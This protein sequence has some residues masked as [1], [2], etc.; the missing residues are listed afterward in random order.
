VGV[1]VRPHGIRHTA[2]TQAIDA[3]AKQGLSI[4][5]VR[6]FSR[7]KSIGTLLVYRDQHENKQRQ[8]AEWVSAT[9]PEVA[10]R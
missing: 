7:H 5:V 10:R 4:D 8:L 2:I 1:H 6:Q 9:V 3:A